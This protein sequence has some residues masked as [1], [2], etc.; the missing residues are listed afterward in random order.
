MNQEIC[1]TFHLVPT[2]CVGTH[3]WTLCVESAMV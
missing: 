2:L 1:H 3:V